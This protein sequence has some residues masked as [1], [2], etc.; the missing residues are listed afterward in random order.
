MPGEDAPALLFAYKAHA[1]FNI[2]DDNRHTPV[3]VF[4]S[5]NLQINVYF[6]I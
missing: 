6:N 4:I 3:R 5:Q 1:M 2:N